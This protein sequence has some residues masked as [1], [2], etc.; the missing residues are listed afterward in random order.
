[1]SV[2]QRFAELANESLPRFAG[3]L[4]LLVVGLIAVRLLSRL[5]RKAL[6][7]AGIDDHAERLRVHDALERAGFGRSLSRAV[8]LALRLTLTLVVVF[9]ALSLLG[10]AALEQSLNAGVLF[11]PRLIAAMAILL[12]GLVLGGFTRE[13]VERLAAQMSLPPSLP[14]LAEAGVI[15]V[16]AVTALAQIGVPTSMLAAV[17]GVIAGAAALT[18][19]LAFGLGSRDVAREASAGRYVSGAFRVGQRIG[20]GEL[21]GEIVSIEAASTVLETDEGGRVRVPNH[22]LLDSVV[23]IDGDPPSGGVPAGAR[24]V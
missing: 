14:P 24:R 9:A 5:T 1:V 4:L 20:L 16:F 17:A 7:V 11:L 15:A 19:A 13:W 2:L 18:F 21:R 12:V 22:M 23:A 10:L 8:E 6:K 3:A